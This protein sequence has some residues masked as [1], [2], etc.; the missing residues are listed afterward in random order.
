MLLGEHR[1]AINGMGQVALPEQ[2]L[3]ELVGAFVVTRGF[4]RNLILFPE[5]EW[6]ELAGRL[7]S[8]PISDHDVRTL[9]RRLFSD[10]VEV[11]VDADGR[12]KLPPSL[13]E[14][15][16]INGEVILVGM[17][18]HVELWSVEQWSQILESVE[19]SSVSEQWDELGV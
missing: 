14:F 16:G 15:A 10:A 6:R 8:K 11:T 2:V 4:E 5:Q 1:Q 13:R 7:M 17:Y 3:S 12:I 9:R 18:D 19:A